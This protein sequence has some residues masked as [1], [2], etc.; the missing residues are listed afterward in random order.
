MFSQEGYS[1]S[2]MKL[3]ILF[4][5]TLNHKSLKMKEFDFEKFF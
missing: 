2:Q 5:E 1:F 4:I 3:A